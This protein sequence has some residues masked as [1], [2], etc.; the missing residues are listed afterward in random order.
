MPLAVRRE[1][2]ISSEPD[3]RIVSTE[4]CSKASLI[5]EG[6]FESVA[7]RRYL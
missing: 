3:T 4:F 7:F 2:K 5:Q 1:N 6:G